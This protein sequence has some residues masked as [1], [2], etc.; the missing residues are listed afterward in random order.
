MTIYDLAQK[1]QLSTS[2][3]SRALNDDPA[4]NHKTRK[5][6]L[7]T[8]RKLVYQH[9]IFASSLR[10][11]KTNTIRVI[12]QELNSH[13]TVS[14]LADIDKATTG[15]GYDLVIA[16]SSEATEKDIANTL[17]RFHKRVDR[18]IAS[19]TFTTGNLDHFIPFRAKEIPLVFFNRADEN[20]NNINV[21]NN[22][23]CGYIAV[24]MQTLKEHS[25]RKAGELSA[26]SVLDH[27]A[28]IFPRNPVKK[29]TIRSELIIRNFS[30]RK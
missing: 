9:N 2:T 18:S 22:Y 23:H 24:C 29:I 27:L 28:G 4:V 1:L 25:I 19:L 26:C 8:A 7:K 10:S 11:R 5:T 16:H 13:F 20:S 17:N 12:K 6:I 21:I 3:I 15:T 14:V 30:V